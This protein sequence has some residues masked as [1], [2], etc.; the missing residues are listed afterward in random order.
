[1]TRVRNAALLAAML[2]FSSAHAQDVGSRHERELDSSRSR[3]R[4]SRT[5]DDAERK[6]MREMDRERHQMRKGER[7]RKDRQRHGN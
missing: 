3:T 2:A 5:F 7:H 4:A 1:M 6:Q